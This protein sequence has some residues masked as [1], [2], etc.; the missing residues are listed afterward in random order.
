M[1][2]KRF[3][4]EEEQTLKNSFEIKGKIYGKL[5]EEKRKTVWF[6]EDELTRA[7]I[8]TINRIR[9]G[10]IGTNEHL[11]KIGLSDTP[12]CICGDKIQTL[13]HIFWECPETQKASTTLTQ[14][15]I[16]INIF[17][18]FEIQSLA[19]SKSKKILQL[20]VKFTR[21]ISHV[22]ALTYT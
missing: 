8:T 3:R 11:Y 6:A 22:C 18:P 4:E 9:S 2:I 19:F 15:L 7:F 14:S 20:I 16:N 17:P 10:H 5:R 21:E 12:L 13:N 1:S